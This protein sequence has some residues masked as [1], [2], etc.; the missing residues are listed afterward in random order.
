MD[1]AIVLMERTKDLLVVVLCVVP[2]P[3]VTVATPHPPEEYASV[4]RVIRL[5]LPII[6]PAKITTNAMIGAFV[7]NY[8][9][10]LWVIS[11]VPVTQGID[12]I[13]MATL[14]LRIVP[15]LSLCTIPMTTVYGT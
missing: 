7:I 12:Y 4:R 8:V 13:P 3:A 15:F 11:T 1:P 10:M 14:V 2:C 5:T 6:G 9:K